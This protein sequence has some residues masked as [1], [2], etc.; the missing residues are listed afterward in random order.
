M[1]IVIILW[2]ITSAYAVPVGEYATMGLCGQ[3]L[4][5]LSTFLAKKPRKVLAETACIPSI[6]IKQDT[7]SEPEKFDIDDPNA[8]PRM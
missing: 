3:Y 4:G 2:L 6:T 5:Q 8:V 1:K 7:T